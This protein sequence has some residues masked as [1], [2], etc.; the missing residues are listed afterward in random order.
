MKKRI[1]KKIS[2]EERE[3]LE[4]KG[5]VRILQNVIKIFDEK[6]NNKRRLR[7]IFKDYDNNEKLTKSILAEDVSKYM[8]QIVLFFS[9]HYFLSYF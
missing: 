5:L 9:S 1:K 4:K 8:L 2:T 7:E 6:K 3:L